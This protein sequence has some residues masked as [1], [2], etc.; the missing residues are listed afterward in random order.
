MRTRNL[1][2]KQ[3]GTENKRGERVLRDYGK[4]MQEVKERRTNGELRMKE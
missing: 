2:N 3:C 4:N 1:L